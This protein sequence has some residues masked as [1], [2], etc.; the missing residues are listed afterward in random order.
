MKCPCCQNEMRRGY[1]HNGNQPVQW[2]PE[3]KKP[4]AFSFST[5]EDGVTL[6]NKFEPIRSNG[7]KAEAHYC[8]KCR[9]V[10]APTL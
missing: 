1:I 6:K 5:A 2:I 3:G 10:V 7:Y 9:L 4:S 8:G